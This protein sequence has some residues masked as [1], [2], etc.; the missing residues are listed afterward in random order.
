MKFVIVGY[1]RV[2]MRTARILQ[3]EGHDLVVVEV[4]AAKA[5][6]A[7][8]EG[9]SVVVG[10]GSEESVLAEAGIAEADA[11]AGLTG[12]LNVNFSACMVG[13]EHGART[14]LRIDEDYREE[15]YDKYAQDVDEVIYPEQLGAVGA[16]TALLG[17][18]FNVVADI[19]EQLSLATVTVPEGSPVVGQRV[20]EVTL[21]GEARIYA[22]CGGEDPMSIPLSQS[23]IAAGDAVA[24]LA[25]HETLDEARAYLRGEAAAS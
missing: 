17:G 2:G 15:L 12:D 22:H 4:D 1:G 23:R 14:V 11:I 25:D 24:V 9:F 19:T 6:R 10:D 16:K 7:E 21:P 13:A 8:D 3:S 5:E 20:V 18:D